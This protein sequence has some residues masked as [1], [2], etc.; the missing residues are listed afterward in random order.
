VFRVI[1]LMDVTDE[2]RSAET[3][4]FVSVLKDESLLQP[5]LNWLLNTQPQ[6]NRLFDD[7]CR[8]AF[9]QTV[10]GFVYQQMKE[11]CQT[12]N[13]GR[14]EMSNVTLVTSSQFSGLLLDRSSRTEQLKPISETTKAMTTPISQEKSRAY[15]RDFPPLEASPKSQ[16]QP[17]L[18]KLRSKETDSQSTPRHFFSKTPKK[19]PLYVRKDQRL[20][21]QLSSTPLKSTAECNINTDT[22]LNDAQ[23]H[24]STN[25]KMNINKD[26]KKLNTVESTK[27]EC[28]ISNV[29][30]SPNGKHNDSDTVR[31]ILNNNDS[32]T[33]SKRTAESYLAVVSRRRS[34]ELL[35]AIYGAIILNK[36]HP[37]S[38]THDIF[39]IFQMLA[40]N[41]TVEFRQR[42]SQSI[43]SDAIQTDHNNEEFL[44]SLFRRGIDFIYFGVHC[45][46]AMSP[47]L[48][49]F[50]VSVRRHLANNIY[51]QLIQPT[52]VQNLN[53]S[54]EFE[55][56]V[57]Y[58]PRTKP[59]PDFSMPLKLDV[60]ANRNN[61]RTP[62]ET[63]VFNNR[64][65][66]RDSFLTIVYDVNL[67]K[68]NKLL[69]TVLPQNYS[70]FCSLF[71]TELLKNT[72]EVMELDPQLPSKID[73]KRLSQLNRRFTQLN[74]IKNF[75]NNIQKEESG[76]LTDHPFQFAFKN[77]KECTLAQFLFAENNYIL[78]FFLI[79]Q[80]KMKINELNDITST[81][82]NESELAERIAQLKT[83]AKFLAFLVFL[84]IATSV[85]ATSTGFTSHVTEIR[86][87][88]SHYEQPIDLLSVLKR[89]HQNAHLCLTLPW[90]CEYLRLL[91]YDKVI[92]ETEYMKKV[93]AFLKT[94][95]RSEQLTLTSA[96]SMSALFLVIELSQLFG[97]LD[98]DVYNSSEDI[99][100]DVKEEFECL[101][102]QQ[103]NEQLALQSSIL[104]KPI[105]SIDSQW[106]LINFDRFVELCYPFMDD[107]TRFLSECNMQQK[108]LLS[109]PLST[110]KGSSLLCVS[111]SDYSIPIQTHKKT[112]KKV[113]PTLIQ[114]LADPTCRLQ[115]VL[116]SREL[117][118]DASK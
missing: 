12:S 65:S 43:A 21:S 69:E 50:T 18:S 101:S 95:Y 79:T 34:L 115:T 11:F 113:T 94:L 60:D 33:L 52:L 45:L 32:D 36:L 78:N 117:S 24:T 2:S 48:S 70:F 114:S 42:S 16:S 54:I 31:E 26:D 27:N 103:P 13:T 104:P 15:E 29:S 71:I 22:A 51:L 91:K 10:L 55:P 77:D 7:C 5:T 106:T 88:L 64:E 118:Y 30:S 19:R 72:L 98:I 99:E 4:L 17:K 44:E 111:N 109:E 9:A 35:A 68:E 23:S 83:L 41:P 82:E 46:K 38:F 62:L 81:E 73:P 58:L 97:D 61:F 76:P 74:R 57:V 63:T 20:N 116:F 102:V 89:A 53:E 107:A 8:S 87:L 84:P 100:F 47:L 6:K 3:Y 108:R 28:E 90:V 66:I 86:R 105:H 40:V 25:D 37:T 59:Y 56:N 67:A 75:N 14:H 112:S 85:P 80:L 92:R 93:F 49:A 96:C 110:K 39:L 1:F